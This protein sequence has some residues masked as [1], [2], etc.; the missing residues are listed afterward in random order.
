MKKGHHNKYYKTLLLF[1]SLCLLTQSCSQK[2]AWPL[3][4]ISEL[5]PYIGS[6]AIQGTHTQLQEIITLDSSG[7]FLSSELGLVEESFLDTIAIIVLNETTLNVSPLIRQ[8]STVDANLLLTN[9]TL[10]IDFDIG[11]ETQV[12]KITGQIWL[13]NN[14]IYLDYRWKKGTSW[15]EEFPLYGDIKANGPKL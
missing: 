9:D 13:N 5:E 12:N 6:Y 4:P 7:N 2:G 3:E 10:N 14:Q 1:V 8:N 11:Q 15:G